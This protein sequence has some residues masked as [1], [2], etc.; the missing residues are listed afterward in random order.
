MS[1]DLAALK[2]CRIVI[3]A[4]LYCARY[5]RELAKERDDLDTIA[6]CAEAIGGIYDR[7]GPIEESILTLEREQRQRL[8]LGSAESPI[9]PLRSGKVTLGASRAFL[10]LS[11]VPGALRA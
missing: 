11:C 1:E 9:E 7:L 4:E 8:A 2:A 3:L 5:A 10:G 6:H